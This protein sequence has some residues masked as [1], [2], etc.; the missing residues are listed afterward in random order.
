MRDFWSYIWSSSFCFKLVLFGNKTITFLKLQSKNTQLRYFWSQFNF[1]CFARIFAIW[2]IQGGWFQLVQL[3]QWLFIIKTQIYI[4]KCFFGP[5]F[6]SLSFCMKLCILI[7]LWMLFWHTTVA[8]A[9]WR[10]NM[11]NYCFCGPKFRLF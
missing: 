1:F 7:N 9:S 5:K 10:L 6:N 4:K 11:P 8:F 3:W 2:K